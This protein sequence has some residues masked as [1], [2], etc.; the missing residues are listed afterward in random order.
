MIKRDWMR[1]TV[2]V[3]DHILKGKNPTENGMKCGPESE[4]FV[5]NIRHNDLFYQI[6]EFKRTLEKMIEYCDISD[7]TID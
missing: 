2:K 3:L 7:T 5:D 1:L 4:W 6:S